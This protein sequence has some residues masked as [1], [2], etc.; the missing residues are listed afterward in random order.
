MDQAE[1]SA[2]VLPHLPR[3]ILQEDGM[4]GRRLRHGLGGLHY[5]PFRFH[6]CARAKDVVS[7]HSWPVH[8]SGSYLDRQRGVNT[9]DRRGH[10]DDAASTALELAAFDTREDRSHLRVWFGILVR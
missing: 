2:D 8:Q 9:V 10:L 6:L 1:P 7:G 3:A 4:G 5:V